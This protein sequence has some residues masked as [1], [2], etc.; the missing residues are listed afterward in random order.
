MRSR[1]LISLAFGAFLLAAGL[2]GWLAYP[3]GSDLSLA[4]P[5]QAWQPDDPATAAGEYTKD[6]APLKAGFQP[7]RY[8][9]F[10]G[11]ASIA[12]VLRAYG[13]EAADQRALFTSWSA[14][15]DAFYTGVTLAE[16]ATLARDVGLRA[17]FEYANTF[18]VDEFRA[19][20]KSNLSQEGDF[21]LVNYDRRVL[22]QSGAGHIS[23][24]GAYDENRDAVLILDEAPYKYPFTWVPVPLLYNA[25]HTRDTGNF[26]GILVV[27]GYGSRD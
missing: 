20:L 21:I 1:I 26:R 7:Q 22:K 2:T 14:K 6:W 12:T 4:P 19:R 5:L 23:A 16:L 9:A 27:Q 10:C 11:P 15:L 3:T 18:A 25:M 24:I 13:A 17:T 8:R